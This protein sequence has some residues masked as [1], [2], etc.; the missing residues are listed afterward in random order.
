MI[1]S[2]R[3]SS[4]SIPRIS[5]VKES[6]LE[7]HRTSPTSREKKKK[8]FC[9]IFSNCTCI[10]CTPNI[11]PVNL[12]ALGE[13]QQRLSIT[14]QDFCSAV[15]FGILV[16]SCLLQTIGIRSLPSWPL[17]TAPRPYMIQTLELAHLAGNN[18]IIIIISDIELVDW[19]FSY[20]SNGVSFFH[21]TVPP[22]VPCRKKWTQRKSFSFDFFDTD[23]SATWSDTFHLFSFDL[24]S[25]SPLC[26]CPVKLVDPV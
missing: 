10:T 19:D 7:M 11:S 16:A 5:V 2:C 23:M 20:V 8:D 18:F 24:T 6:V 3:K 26:Y 25:S 17:F 22:F 13:I 21:T 4:Q 9:P 12:F 14:M 1:W 15:H